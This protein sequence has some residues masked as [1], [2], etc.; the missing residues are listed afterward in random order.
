MNR[1]IL[2]VVTLSL[3]VIVL[4]DR[5]QHVRDLRHTLASTGGETTAVAPA[6][7][8]QPVASDRAEVGR[9]GAT[10]PAM[11]RLARL[12]ARQHLAAVAGYAYLDSLLASTDSVVRR[13]PDPTSGPL[14]VAIVEGGADGYRPRMATFVRRALAL[15]E[16]TDAGV[17]FETV[18]DTAAADIVIRWIDRFP[19]DRAGQTDITWDRAGRVRHAA[20]SLAIRTSTGLRLPDASLFAVA[21]HETGHAIGLPH[22]ADSADVMFPATRVGVLTPRD[23]RTAQVLYALP[24]GPVTDTIR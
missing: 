4:V 5:V 7:A 19:F 3:A 18:T 11:D 1:Y 24:I 22:S 14:R 21:V 13:W 20:V 16:E 17:Q 2:P 6:R 10:A 23:R 8:N 12:A 15:W 9:A